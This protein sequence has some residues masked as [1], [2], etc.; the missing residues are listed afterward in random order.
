MSDDDE[1]WHELANS[2]VEIGALRFGSFTLSSGKRSSYY[3]DLRTVP[4][5][6]EVYALV[7]KAYEIMIGRLGIEGFDAIGGIA[8]AGLTI[9]SPLAVSL[10][11]PMVY[12]RS[13]E[14]S[15]GLGKRVEGRIQNGWRV[16]LVDDVATT[17]GSITDAV[18][19][20]RAEG[21]TVKDALVL[22]DRLE[23]GT[24][25]LEARGVRLNSFV[26]VRGLVDM[27]H[28]DKALTVAERDAILEQMTRE[29]GSGVERTI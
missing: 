25:N 13:E 3:L 26:T 23:G 18:E 7:L 29:V 21:F 10:K 22:V 19:S 17:G 5:Y 15:H 12:V 14:K 20:L 27:L 11:K 8:T 24:R 2:L 1:L 9:S 4:S 28:S 16:V 6:P